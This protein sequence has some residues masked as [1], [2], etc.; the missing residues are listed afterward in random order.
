R[1]G[2][3]AGGRLSSPAAIHVRGLSAAG[4]LDGTVHGVA[5]GLAR[6]GIHSGRD[7]PWTVGP[8]RL[9]PGGCVADT[10]AHCRLA[11][12]CTRL[13]VSRAD[14]EHDLRVMGLDGARYRLRQDDQS[15]AMGRLW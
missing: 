12:A 15:A 4:P 9:L 10:G 2:S 5:R 8:L 3:A 6:R 7:R 13:R 14:A 11:T 1:P